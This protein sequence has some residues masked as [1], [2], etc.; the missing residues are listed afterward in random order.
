VK[1]IYK[2]VHI[3]FLSKHIRGTSYSELALLFNERFGLSVTEAAVKTLCTK[4]GLCNGIGHGTWPK[5]YTE[6]Q[7][8]FLKKNV[9][10]CK[11]KDLVALFNAKFGTSAT[12]SAIEQACKTRGL[13]NE[14]VLRWP[15]GHVPHNKGKKG[16][17]SPGSEKGWFGP[18]HPGYKY[19][20]MPIGSERIT[21]DGYVEVKYSNDP[22]PPNRRWKG[23][24]VAIWEKA[25]GPVPKGHVIVFADGDRENFKLNNLLLVSRRELAVLNHGGLLSNN[26]YITEICVNIARLKV[27]SA[28]RKRGSFDSVTDKKLIVIDN[29]GRRIVIAYDSKKDRYFPARKTKYGV[30]RLKVKFKPRKTISEAQEDL[31]AYALKRGWHRE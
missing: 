21:V 27:L 15:K 24:Q 30:Q 23:K 2:P 12:E 17:C 26:R 6:E 16:Y 13:R 7:I 4:N 28:D 25:N 3:R 19:N 22:G 29:K 14:V 10:G 20:E 5:K 8:L 31:I 9:K 1:R 11:Y 18:G